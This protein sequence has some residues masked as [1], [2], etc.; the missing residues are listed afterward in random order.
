MLKSQCVID[1]SHCATGCG[2]HGEVSSEN[3][4]KYVMPRLVFSA[5]L[6]I[7]AVVLDKVS[8]SLSIVLF[9]L[10]YILS[11]YEVIFN[12]AKNILKGKVFDENFLM[13]IA[14]IGA[15]AIGEYAEGVAVMIFY[16]T[17][18]YFQDLA[19]DKSTKTIESLADL[20]PDIIHLKRNGSIVDVS[21]DQAK[22]GDI[23]TVYAGERVALDGKVI[24]GRGFLDTSMV[25]GESL[26]EDVYEGKKVLS[27]SIN[28]DGA[29]EVSV[30]AE[31]KDSTASKIIKLVYDA[32]N[33]KPMT[34]RFISRFAKV[35]TPIV[36]VCAV[37]IAAIPPVF[38]G[39]FSLWVRRALIFL[40]ASCPC[41]LVVSVPLSFY[42]GIGAAGKSGIVVKGQS[43]LEKLAK[44]NGV[45]F[46][47]TGTLTEN[48]LKID[49]IMPH[50]GYSKDTLLKYAAYAEAF[51][52]HP[53]AKAVTEA[54]SG[55]MD[56]DKI[57]EY[58]ELSGMGVSI[59]LNGKTVLAG[60]QRLLD[61]VNITA[62]KSHKTAL[63]LSVDNSYVGSIEFTETIKP[64]AKQAVDMLTKKGIKSYMFTGDDKNAAKEVAKVVGIKSYISDMLPA[65]KLDRFNKMGG[66]KAFV[67]DGINDA[68][69]LAN[70]DVGIAMGGLGRDAAI[71][72]ADVVIMND[73][74]KKVAQAVEIAKKTLNIVY[75]NVCFALFV[76]L[77]VFA[78]VLIGFNIPMWTA[79]FAD[80]GVTLITVVNATRLIL[81]NA[82]D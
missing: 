60:N 31:L 48:K 40:V 14:T 46:D 1:K 53:I 56:K 20:R 44:L 49:K 57:L 51:S 42:A 13:T 68:P 32:K 33:N 47:K 12:A 21:P 52:A 7:A 24:S 41:A 59:I 36:V 61:T 39:D 73:K 11:G 55:Q 34:A 78:L 28:T 63:H 71:E 80:V 29:I 25:T 35:Y 5:I 2:C 4:N 58:K 69:V 15:F 82:A 74:P 22:I 43:F 17:G 75:Q 23:Y 8:F 66:L 37:L 64:D 54:C 19:V 62:P 27:G 76:K 70:A 18:E 45:V 3:K 10:A 30:T 16:K 67:G 77:A 81:K 50:E 9:I 79:V 65:D 6:T 38:W 26:P 72:A